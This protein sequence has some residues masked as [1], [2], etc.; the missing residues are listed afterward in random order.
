[1]IKEQHPYWPK[2]T[3]GLRDPEFDKILAVSPTISFAN[4]KFTLIERFKIIKKFDITL[5]N[6]IKQYVDLG[7]LTHTY[8]TNGI[9]ESLNSW[10]NNIN[11]IGVLPNEYTYYERIANTRKIKLIDP[12]KDLDKCDKVV[13]SCPF[14]YD[15]NTTIQ[16]ELIYA[17][18]EKDIPILLDMAYLGVTNTF[19]LDI[20]RNKRVQI[21]YTMSKHFALPFDRLGIVWSSHEDSE[22][23]ILNQVG[24]VNITAIQRAQLLVDNFDL[25]YI[26]NKYKQQSDNVIKELG[27][28]TTECVLFGHKDNEKFCITEYLYFGLS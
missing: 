11:T 22:L 16:Q 12:R 8:I 2:L 3:K 1:M 28:K 20:S 6:K 19:T 14:S 9:T 17:C 24:Y 15:G 10:I 18:A 5:R 27:L 26:Y 21:A 4:N 13:I 25:N 23:S 7:Q